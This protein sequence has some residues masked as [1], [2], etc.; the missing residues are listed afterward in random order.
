VDKI[1]AGRS[2]AAGQRFPDTRQAPRYPVAA[3]SQALDPLTGQ[4]LAG[5][6]SVISR[7]GCYFRTV[8]TLEAGKILQLR[9]ERSGA[10][11]ETWARVVHEIRGDGMGLA[12]FD[13]VPSHMELLKQWIAE[14][15]QAMAKP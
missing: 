1:S 8:T 5:W 10:F 4:E 15:A 13:A 11:L 12:F 2:V 6:I 14:L 3:A 7:S 9:I